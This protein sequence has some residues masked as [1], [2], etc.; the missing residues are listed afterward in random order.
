MSLFSSGNPTVSLGLQ[1]GGAHG[2][3][4]WGVLDYLLEDGR[5]DFDGVSGTSAGAMNAVVLAHGLATGGRRGARQALHDFWNAVATRA[6]IDVT[7][8]SGGS[9]ALMPA[10]KFMLQWTHFLSPEQ[11]NPFNFNPLRDILEEQLDFEVV[12]RRS[13]VN[14]FIAATHANSGRLRLFREQELTAEMVLASA[15]LPSLHHTILIDGEPYWDGGYSANPAIFPLVYDC[16]CKDILL[17]MLAPLN[18]K[19][20]PKT[21]AEI[22]SRVLELAFN[23]TFLREMRMFALMRENLGKWWFPRVTRLARRVHNSR[24]HIVEAEDFFGELSADTKLATSLGFL[25]TLRDQGRQRARQWLDCH[26]GAIG[27]TCSADLAVM[28]G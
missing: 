24:F 17:V 25:E 5:V 8:P 9:V 22:N 7:I 13:P 20:T 23:A 2:A 12:R 26:F 15:C 3:F 16:G 10:V 21:A 1:G 18:H 19:K 14:L 11:L 4:T 28:F 6:P 27:R